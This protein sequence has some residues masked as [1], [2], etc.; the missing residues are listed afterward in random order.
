MIDIF[1]IFTGEQKEKPKSAIS[2]IFNKNTRPIANSILNIITEFDAYLPMTVRQVYYQLVAREIIPNNINSYQKISRLLVKLRDIE[3]IPWTAI[4]DRS[5][6]TTDKRGAADVIT[7]VREQLEYIDPRNYGR[8]LIKN[9]E[10]YV[11]VSVEKDAVS[12]IL[13]SELWTYCTRLNVIRGQGSRTIIEQIAGR[14]DRAAMNGQNP[15]L[16][17][18]GDLDPSG[19]S[20]PNAI[21][22]TMANVHHIDVDVRTLALSPEQVKKYNLPC[23]IDAV[24]R[25][26]PNYKKWI[27]QYGPEQPAVELDALHP[28]TLKEILLSALSDVYN[29]DAMLLEQDIEKEDRLFIRKLKTD[30]VFFLK[31]K[32]PNVLKVQYSAPEGKVGLIN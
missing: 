31:E 1:N 17:H 29:I 18:F 16:L 6:R 21:K 30:L 19:V 32:Y 28:E 3:I 26:D 2:S 9:Q 24:K 5:R 20:I 10:N 23:S 8:C 13:E 27:N 12:S 11:E 22:N 15:I 4:E 25:T 7:W 14:F